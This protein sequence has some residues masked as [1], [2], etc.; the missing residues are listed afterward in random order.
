MMSQSINQAAVASCGL[1]LHTVNEKEEE[2]KSSELRAFVNIVYG[3]HTMTGLEL[4][5]IKQTKFKT[6]TMNCFLL[7]FFLYTF[8]VQDK[9][10]INSN[11]ELIEV[12][13]L[14]WEARLIVCILEGIL[15][16]QHG[17]NLQRESDR[18]ERERNKHI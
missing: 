15:S 3:V 12:Q 6:T 4:K 2:E 7:F 5:G 16:S 9:H 11:Q 17:V 13:E 18:G 8:A 1:L 10:K 14:K